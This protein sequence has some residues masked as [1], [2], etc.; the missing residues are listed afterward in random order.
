MPSYW[1]LSGALENWGVALEKGVWGV[2]ERTRE[3]WARV[4]LGN[5]V[6]FHAKGMAVIGYDIVE[7]K[8]E[9]VVVW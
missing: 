7:G 2:S 1:A 5:V 8:F 3:P 4:Q 9:T 6:A